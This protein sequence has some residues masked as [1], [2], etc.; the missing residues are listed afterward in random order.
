MGSIVSPSRGSCW[1]HLGAFLVPS[2]S[3][4]R[5]RTVLSSKKLVFVK[6][7]K[8]FVFHP[9]WLPETT[10]DRSKMG[11]R[12]SRI[13]FSFDLSSRFWIVW[14]SIL[15]PCW[16]PKRSPGGGAELYS[17]APE[18]SKTVLKSS[19]FGTLVVLSFG[20]AFL[21]VSGSF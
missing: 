20:I 9:R 15:V 19:W 14:R 1:G 12:S 4:N 21:V 6:H 7:S 2:C 17:S 13:V 16:A 8:L 3:R 5:L 10:Q 11:P 18:G